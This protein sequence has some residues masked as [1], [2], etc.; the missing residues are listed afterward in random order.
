M[1]ECQRRGRLAQVAPMNEQMHPPAPPRMIALEARQGRIGLHLGATLM[2]K[3][4]CVALSGGD[5]AH[6]GAVALSQARASLDPD[7]G[8]SATTSVLALLGHKEDDLARGLAAKLAISL[9]A[10]VCVACGIHVE[11]LEPAEL[12]IVAGLAEQL[13]QE[14]L[15][16]LGTP[17]G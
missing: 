5:R 6:I 9:E 14:L 8:T 7:G 10:T 16:R 11:G 2:G 4:L 17:R 12:P 3:D 15:E 13:C 1:G